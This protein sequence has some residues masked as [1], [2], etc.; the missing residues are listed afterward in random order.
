IVSC[1]G[2]APL[3]THP[4]RGNRWALYSRIHLPWTRVTTEQAAQD[5]DR[6]PTSVSP[7]PPAFS[8]T[9]SPPPTKEY[10]EPLQEPQH[11]KPAPQTDLTPTPLP[12][13][14]PTSST[15]ASGVTKQHTDKKPRPRVPTLNHLVPEDLQETARLLTLFERAQ[16][17]GLIGKSDS[18]RLTFLGLAEHAKMV[19]SANPCGLFAALVRRQC[20]HFI[21]DSDE[22]AAQQRLKT[23]LYGAASQT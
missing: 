21:T 8:T 1:G 11:Q 7:P 6:T 15:S 13:K 17:H 9:E 5:D 2:L 4:A 12:H 20:W 14:A 3:D 23:H 18:E 19:G 10:R 22:D 16:A